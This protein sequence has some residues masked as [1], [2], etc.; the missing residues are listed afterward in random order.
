MVYRYISFE[1]C[2][3]LFDSL[4]FSAICC[5][6]LSNPAGGGL[7]YST[8]TLSPLENE[9]NVAHALVRD[10]NYHYTHFVRILLT[11]FDLLPLIN[12]LTSPWSRRGDKDFVSVSRA[13][14]RDAAPPR[15]PA[16]PRGVRPQRGAAGYGATVHAACRGDGL[17]WFLHRQVCEKRLQRHARRRSRFK[18]IY[19]RKTKESSREM[20]AF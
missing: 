16:R 1:S 7:I 15:G 11:M 9:A 20:G 8:C 4:P 14:P 6:R 12:L 13:R 2:S 5:S 18:L 3:H 17:Q 10:L 19:F